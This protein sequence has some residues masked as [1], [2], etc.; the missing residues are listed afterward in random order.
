MLV[1][2]REGCQTGLMSYIR[3]LRPRRFRRFVLQNLSAM[4]TAHETPAFQPL[5]RQIKALITRS[6]MSGEWR[7]GEPIPSE[8]E[9]ASRYSVSQGTVRKAVG[10]LAEENVLV[11]QQGKG[12]FVASHAAERSQFPFLRIAPD[13]EALGEL[14][15]ELLGLERLRDAI[16]ARM[17]GLSA[18]AGVYLLKRV[19]RINGRT[20]CYEEIRL[21]SARFKGLTAAVVEHHECMLYSMYETRFGVRTL[22]AEERLK[23]VPAPAEAA[24]ALQVDE[25]EPLLLV[26]RMAFTYSRE[27]C[28]LRLS[29]CDTRLHHYR[30]AITG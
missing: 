28:E 26:D 20:A 13:D 2:E 29:Y 5:Y 6:L 9:L 25:G 10:E 15:A 4:K 21:P 27:P 23:A 14:T 19:L 22:H 16:A 7:P 18:G 11:R 3:Y 8:M 17:L 30:N 12:T 24:A 1:A